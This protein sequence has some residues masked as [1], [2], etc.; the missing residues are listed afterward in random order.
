VKVDVTV[1]CPVHDSF[2]VQ[3]V[4]SLF[5]VAISKKAAARF[6]VE[7]PDFTDDWQIG[8]I[9]GPSGS[10]KSTVA[11]EAFPREWMWDSGRAEWAKDKAV[12]DDFG[13]VSV[14]DVAGVL[15]S[16]GFSSP[17]SWVK[18]YHV[19]SNGEKFRCDLARSLLSSV[20]IVTFDE[21]S[22][23]VD[24]NV[25]QIGSAAVAKTIRGGKLPMRKKFVAVTC[26]YDVLDWLEP[27]WVLDMASCTLVRGSVRR[28]PTIELEVCTST[29][30]AWPMFAPYHYLSATIH[31]A[32]KCYVA[33]WNDEPV[34]FCSVMATMGHVGRSRISRIVVLP[35]YQGVGI[36]S[37]VME[38]VASTVKGQGRR[39]SI[40]ASHP[41]I[42]NHCRRSKLWRFTEQKPTGFCKQW[43]A[44]KHTG[45]NH[46]PANS[47]GRFV[48]SYEYIGP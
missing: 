44:G 18:P 45:H 12:V 1:T 16:V 25:A 5:D 7:I 21:Y 30:A 31:P 40:V 24:R 46:A 22:S 9:V 3:Q 37:R 33:T 17:P 28:R 4:S 23:V 42:R 15:T 39:I 36:G 11:R 34:A 13:D 8:A 35:D 19:L 26:H 2:R 48:E 47:A 27:D 43:Q 10:G 29:T 20:P 32:S 38:A 41:G 6:S 14:K